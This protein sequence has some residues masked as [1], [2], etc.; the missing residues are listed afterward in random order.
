M[1][2]QILKDPQQ[3]IGATVQIVIDTLFARIKA[4]EYPVETRLPSERTLA[5]ERVERGR[6]RAVQRRERGGAAPAG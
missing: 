3:P 2:Q 6:Q 4:E 1:N 5:A